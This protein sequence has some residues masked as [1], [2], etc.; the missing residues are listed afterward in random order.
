MHATTG[1][2]PLGPLAFLCLLL[3]LTGATGGIV[4]V[5]VTPPAIQIDT[6]NGTIRGGRCRE[7]DVDYFLSIPYA[8]PP[9]GDLRFAPPVPHTDAYDGVLDGSVAAPACPQFGASFVEKGP[10]DEDWLAEVRMFSSTR[11]SLIWPVCSS[12]FGNQLM[13]LQPP[14]CL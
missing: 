3:G 7:T 11:R 5:P 4:P 14:D 12:M 2:T 9:I 10:Q 13:Q 1:A 8:Q 6:L